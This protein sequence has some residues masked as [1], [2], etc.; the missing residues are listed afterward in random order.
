M[1]KNSVRLLIAGALGT[2]AVLAVNLQRG[3][4]Q[5]IVPGDS[6]YQ[7][8]CEAVDATTVE[9][10]VKNPGT[11]II[12]INGDVLFRFTV[13]NAMSRPSIQ[14]KADALIPSGRTV[15][16]ARARVATNLL[17]GEVCQFDVS[18]AVR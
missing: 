2:L 10:F 4:A 9:G 16:V 11:G 3:K 12:R 14:V 18:G 13:A 17:P 1:I 15:S 7:T 6:R 5:L 8:G